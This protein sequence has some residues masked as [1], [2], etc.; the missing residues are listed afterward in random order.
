MS[1]REPSGQPDEP[2]SPQI[3]TLEINGRPTLVF[4]AMDLAEA[5]EIC[6]DADLRSDKGAHL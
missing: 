2:R 4:E 3:F 6:L 5:S 1:M